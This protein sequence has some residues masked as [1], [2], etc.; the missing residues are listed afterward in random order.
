MLLRPGA[1]LKGKLGL[2]V[3]LEPNDCDVASSE[4]CALLADG[5]KFSPVQ[6]E[7]KACTRTFSGQSRTSVM[8]EPKLIAC[9]IVAKPSRLWPNVKQPIGVDRELRE[10]SAPRRQFSDRVTKRDGNP[11]AG[12]QTERLCRH[13]QKGLPKTRRHPFED[14]FGDLWRCQ[15]RRRFNRNCRHNRGNI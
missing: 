2:Q 10:R 6:P 5:Q 13:A 4:R 8:P 3:E 1:W 9:Q 11:I 7:E 14:F 12:Q 15:R